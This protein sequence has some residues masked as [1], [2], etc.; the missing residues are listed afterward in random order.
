MK[1][2]KDPWPEMKMAIENETAEVVDYFRSGHFG[3][4]GICAKACNDEFT[5][6]E[7]K[8]PTVP[9]DQSFGS[10]TKVSVDVES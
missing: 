4:N 8:K 2:D 7:Q 10:L 3:E 5:E 6:C 1:S 9:A